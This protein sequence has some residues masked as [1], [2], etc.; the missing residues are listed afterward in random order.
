MRHCLAVVIILLSLSNLAFGPAVLTE[1][2]FARSR[3]TPYQSE[4]MVPRTIP[5]LT[6]KAAL[7]VDG[8]SGTTLYARNEHDRLPPASTTKMVTALLAVEGANLGERVAILPSDLAVGS[9]MGLSATEEPTLRELLYGLL[10]VSDNAAAEIIAR[11]V[12]GSRE[13]FMVAMNSWLAENGLSDTHFGNPHGLDEANHY[14]SA[15]DLVTIGLRL[16]ES[17]VL[18]EIV[19]TRE[20][21]AASRLLESTNELL[22]SYPGA[23][24]IK[25]GTT[26]AAGQCLVASAERG[27]S[28]A[29]AV[30]LGSRDRYGDAKALLDYYFGGYRQVSLGLEP[31][32]LARIRDSEGVWRPLVTRDT[33]RVL[34]ARWQSAYLCSFLHIEV[35]EVAGTS[36]E[37]VGRMWYLLFDRKVAEFPIYVGDY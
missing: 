27:E 23:S 36:D 1:S 12:A 11:H 19:S 10:L 31:S 5:Q 2:D 37:P 21:W 24:G 34:M 25:T 22:G 33:V 8:A 28:W 16:L 35:E 6:A 18:A 9:V 20:Q 26:D 7:L 30:V 4:L 17:P 14:S 3:V 32:P 29:L 15:Q 13:S